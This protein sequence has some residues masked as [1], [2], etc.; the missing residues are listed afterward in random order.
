MKFPEQ[1]RWTNAPDDYKT[2][3]GDPF[4]A[5]RIP[6]RHANGRE[7]KVI[8]TD[9]WQHVSVSLPDYPAK[10]PS[11]EEMCIVK[12]LFWEDTELVVQFHVPSNDHINR[13]QVLHLW[14]PSKATIPTPPKIC[15]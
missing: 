8:A 13:A 7:L 6:P 10:T 15:V 12:N 3:P 5:F 14:R 2:K 9:G 1:F 4:G 11:W